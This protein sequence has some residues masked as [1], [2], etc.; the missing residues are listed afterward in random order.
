M[1]KRILL[2]LGL[3][4]ISSPFLGAEASPGNNQSSTALSS[5]CLITLSQ[6]NS[7]IIS[8]ETVY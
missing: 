8:V 5:R 6:V 7:N 3:T 2:L 1:T 4:M